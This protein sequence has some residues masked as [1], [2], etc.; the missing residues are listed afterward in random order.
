MGDSEL[1]KESEKGR[2]GVG[3][4]GKIKRGKG[5]AGPSGVN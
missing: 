1:R 3:F 4:V 2:K 5:M